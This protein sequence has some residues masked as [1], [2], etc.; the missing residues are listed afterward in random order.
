MDEIP[1]ETL[2]LLAKRFKLLAHPDRLAVL[3]HLCRGER[4]VG[5][6]QTL[7]GLA[8]A[9]LSRQLALL[10]AGGLVRRRPHGT[11]AYYALADQT[12]PEICGVARRGLERR[13]DEILSALRP[14][15]RAR[16]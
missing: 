14:A 4:S 5:E 2:V 3:M 15:R 11:R 13:H 1:R 8:Q 16:R 7:T 12:L 6:L 9:N 10:D